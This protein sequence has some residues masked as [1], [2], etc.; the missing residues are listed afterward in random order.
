MKCSIAHYSIMIK[1]MIWMVFFGGIWHEQPSNVYKC[2]QKKVY[3][4]YTKT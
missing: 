4:P 1:K 3:R 2:V